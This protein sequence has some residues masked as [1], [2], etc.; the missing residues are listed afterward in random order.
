MSYTNVSSPTKNAALKD[1]ELTST[2]TTNENEKNLEHEYVQAVRKASGLVLTEGEIPLARRHSSQLVGNADAGVIEATRRLSGMKAAIIESNKVVEEEEEDRE[3]EKKYYSIIDSN[4]D[5]LEQETLADQGWHEIT[6]SQVYQL[7]NTKENGLT[8][9][10]YQKRADFY[11]PNAITP[12][13][14]T[15]WFIK[16]LFNLVSGFQLMLWFGAVLCFVVYGINTDDIQT[17]ALAVVLIIVVM[18]TTIFQSYQEGK[19]DKVMAALKA[20]SPSTVFVFRDGELQNVP[21]ETL[22][23]GDIVKVTGGEKVPADVRVITSSDLKVNNASLTGENVDIKLGSEANHKDLYEAKNVARSGCNFTSGNAVCVVYA[24]GD[25]TFFGQ[26]ASSMT[27]TERPDTLMKHEIHRLINIMAVVAFTLG[28]AF[29]ILAFLNGYTWVE[30]LVF[31]I[32]IVVANVPEG[33]LPQMT[34]A[35]T[36]T[37]QRMLRL[38][39]LVSNLEII[40]TLG[41]VDIICSDK[42]GTLTCNRMSVSHVAYAKEITITPISPIVD[43]DTFESFDEKN[44]CFQALQRIATLNTDAIFLASSANEPDVLKKETK[45]DASESAIIKFVEPLR[46]IAEYRASCRRV[47]SIPF[48]SS[49]KWMLAIHCQEKTTDP[50]IAMIKGAPERVMNM[51]SHYLDKDG[52]TLHP[53]TPEAR[54]EWEAVNETLA[55]RGERV[56]AFAHKILPLSEYP[57]DYPFDVD[58]EPPNYPKTGLTLVGLLSLIDPPRLSVKPAIAQCNSAGIKVFMV[59]GDHPITAHAIAKSLNLITKPTKAE[60]IFD[61]LEVPE[62]YHE[63]IVIHGTEMLNFTEADWAHVLRHKEIVFARTMPQQK[64]DIVRELNKLGNVVAMTG[65]GVNDAPA[66]KAANVG[67][68][69]GS[70]ASVAKEAAQICLLNDDF[71]AIVDGIREGRLIFENLKKCIAY[72]LSSNVPEIVP[73]LLFIAMKIPLAIETIC[74][75][76]I[77]LG[78]DLAPAVSVAYE[79]PEDSIMQIPP[80][81]DTDHMVG[82]QMMMVAYGTIGIFQTFAA[83]FAYC[84]V[85]YDYGFNIDDL[86]GSGLSYRDNWDDLSKSRQDFFM[87]LCK[88]NSEYYDPNDPKGD[89]QCEGEFVSYRKD[90]LKDA[91]TAYLVTVVW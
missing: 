78:T 15:H 2:V 47:F 75:L 27:A 26:I 22:V 84:Y 59:T 70:G 63:A 41:A 28:I 30:A 1:T 86:I 24:T 14:Q 8:S 39:V 18:V 6:I 7:L 53:M 62:D 38:G 48:N 46:S 45:G 72:V 20:L 79:E 12:P 87:K 3:P 89:R 66:L 23:P 52:V 57:H 11:G 4:G 10:E 44:L 60:L 81:K 42:T 67:I 71:G 5:Y 35:L 58:S 37:A 36:L 51:C 73:F 19:S 76:L 65:D 88:K 69:M 25:F 80:R 9:E 77:D 90:A 54:A 31:M 61:G 68:A 34:V 13:K 43:G 21:A 64:Q 49:N 50:L 85:F 32:G 83:F 17:L 40:E 82:P 16:F 56:L 29:F 33:L 74:I 91:Q 55:R